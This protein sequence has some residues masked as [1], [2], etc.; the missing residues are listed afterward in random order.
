MYTDLD[1]GDSGFNIEYLL[2]LLSRG[3]LRRKKVDAFHSC[4]NTL[5]LIYTVKSRSII[6]EK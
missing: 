2:V 1:R 5:T 4:V 6:F 3:D